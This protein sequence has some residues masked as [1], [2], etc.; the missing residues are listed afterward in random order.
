MTIKPTS[1]PKSEIKILL[2]ENIHPVAAEAFAAEGFHVETVKGS[3]SEAELVERCRD[4]HVV[5]IR[6]KTRITPPVLDEARRMLAVGAFCIGTNQIS[7]VHANK[8][9][10]PAFN[11]PFSNTRSVA[12][13]ILAEVVMLSRGRGRLGGAA[14]KLPSWLRHWSMNTLLR[15]SAVLT[16]IGLA[17]MVWSMMQPTPLPVMLAMS[18][19][20]LLGTSAFIIYLIVIVIDLRRVRRARRESSRQIP[21][22]KPGD[23]LLEGD[24]QT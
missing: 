10:I 11:A 1:F 14:M 23:S 9:G 18:V 3:L 13:M 6:S 7:L 12:E 16:M 2:L 22:I 4:V 15:V 20:Q 24:R 17:F 19:G 21:I 5:G 8:C